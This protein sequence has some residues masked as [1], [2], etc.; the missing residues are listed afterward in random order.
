MQVDVTHWKDLAVVQ[1]KLV[2]KYAPHALHAWV[3]DQD[4]YY[5]WEI[6]SPAHGGA[7]TVRM[8][9][10]PRHPE[11]CPQL[12][13]W[14]PIMLP[15]HVGL[16]PGQTVNGKGRC[17]QFHTND[18]GPGGRVCICH[19]NTSQWEPS[20]TYAQVLLKGALW[21]NAYAAHL[22]TGAAVA[23]YFC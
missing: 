18:N 7:F 3:T 22:R 19:I 13:V 14:D 4:A 17:H 10:V 15:L 1:F 11:V 9:Y 16:F 5:Q 2:R 8:H 23:E 21:I 12:Y 20:M 6:D